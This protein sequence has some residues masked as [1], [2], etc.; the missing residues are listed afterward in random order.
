MEPR[1]PGKKEK[2]APVGG[3]NKPTLSNWRTNG[4]GADVLHEVKRI[5]TNTVGKR[6]E[7]GLTRQV[8]AVAS[9]DTHWLGKG[10]GGIVK[11]R[12]KGSVGELSR[13]GREG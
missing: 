9:H 6:E 12:S 13:Q 5:V 8:V 1:Y 10:E 11:K 7:K 4:E 3:M 2:I